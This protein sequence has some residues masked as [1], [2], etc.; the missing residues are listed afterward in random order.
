MKKAQ[1]E[2][3]APQPM[4]PDQGESQDPV[5]PVA[6]SALD[7]SQDEILAMLAV[8]EVGEGLPDD[9]LEMLLPGGVADGRVPGIWWKASLFL[10]MYNRQ[11]LG[12]GVTPDEVS[13]FKHP[14]GCPTTKPL[15]PFPTFTMDQF[16]A[17]EDCV[18][19]FRP[20]FLVHRAA[21]DVPDG[22]PSSAYYASVKGDKFARLKTRNQRAAELIEA[23]LGQ[24]RRGSRAALVLQQRIDAIRQELA[25]LGVSIDD[26]PKRAPRS[27][28]VKKQVRDRLQP[29]ALFD[30]KKYHFDRAWKALTEGVTR[31]A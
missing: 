8:V 5:R 27:G 28:G 25:H 6:S 12:L 24:R 23:L 4:D 15:L 16:I 1:G 31:P 22:S 26:V 21:D 30:G 13:V 9:L 14:T 11:G 3:A 19:V 17:F 20:A 2:L 29:M 18:H 7:Y 10:D